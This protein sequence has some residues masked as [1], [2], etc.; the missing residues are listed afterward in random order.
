MWFFFHG[1]AK[2]TEGSFFRI[3][4]GIPFQ[5][6]A[7]WIWVCL[8]PFLCC[9]E[10]TFNLLW[11]PFFPLLCPTLVSFTLYLFLACL[12]LPGFILQPRVFNNCWQKSSG[13]GTTIS[14]ALDETI[15]LGFWK[16]TRRV[17]T[18][19]GWNMKQSSPSEIVWHW[20]SFAMWPKAPSTVH[21]S[22]LKTEVSL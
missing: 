10:E 6:F 13:Q 12:L 2:G 4:G 9:T 22:N 5:N 20:T 19:R 21:R 8:L 18:S 11:S 1:R 16:R 14:A 7:L 3:S 17:C 15:Q